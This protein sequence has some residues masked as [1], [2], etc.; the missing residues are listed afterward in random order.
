MIYGSDPAILDSD[1]FSEISLDQTVD[2][3]PNYS[4]AQQAYNPLQN[5]EPFIAE[6]DTREESTFNPIAQA[7]AIKDS[8]S[9]LPG[10]ASSVLSSFSSIL[11]G[12]AP[13]PQ[14]STPQ[15]EPISDSYNST[16]LPNQYQYSYYNYDQSNQQVEAPAGPPPTFYS[17]TDSSILQQP[18]AAPPT[19]AQPSNS[20]R[21][22]ERKKVS[23]AP[24]PGF[25]ANTGQPPISNSPAPP[26]APVTDP[27]TPKSN[28]S[29]FSLTTFF[30]SPLIDKIQNTVLP[31]SRLV[32]QP[33]A[34]Q[35]SDQFDISVQQTQ[36][37]PA[38]SNHP[39][40]THYF[41]P[42][43][44]NTQPFA[45]K[46]NVSQPLIANT[47]A[48]SPPAFP[49]PQIFT[50]SLSANTPATPTA[51]TP[52]Q[53]FPP[54]A[55]GQPTGQSFLQPTVSPLPSSLSTSAVSSASQ[56]PAP[57]QTPT[58]TA[59]NQLN[60]QQTAQTTGSGLPFGAP[61]SLPPSAAPQASASYRLKG[62]PLYRKPPADSSYNT[63]PAQIQ[64][65]SQPISD[66]RSSAEPVAAPQSPAVNIFN[67]FAATADTPV[68]P[69]TQIPPSIPPGP[70]PFYV[71]QATAGTQAQPP[72]QIQTSHPPGASP[73]YVPQ[74]NVETPVQSAF[75]IPTSEPAAPSPF[76]V[77]QIS[78]QPASQINIFN[79]SA[80]RSETLLQPDATIVTST[81]RSSPLPGDTVAT[82]L[83]ST[84]SP[85]A[86]QVPHLN[87]NPFASAPAPAST[88]L[89][90]PPPQSQEFSTVLPP[91]LCP[92][93]NPSQISIF[94]PAENQTDPIVLYQQSLQ[95]ILSAPAPPIAISSKQSDSTTALNDPRL[96]ASPFAPPPPN[97]SAVLAAIPLNP[98]SPSVS[99]A[100]PVLSPPRIQTS[101][102]N[103]SIFDPTTAEASRQAD[104]SPFYEFA[105]PE[106]QLPS[107][108]QAQFQINSFFA[109]PTTT[110]TPSPAISVGSSSVSQQKSSS[111]PPQPPPIIN[112]IFNSFESNVIQPQ[113][114]NPFRNQALNAIDDVLNHLT[115]DTDNN[116]ISAVDNSNKSDQASSVDES[117]VQAESRAIDPSSFFNNNFADVAPPTS[118]SNNTNEFQIQNFF[119][120]PPPLSDTQE[121]VQDK[122][123]NFIGTNLLNK[124]IEKIAS[125]ATKTGADTSETLSIASYIVEPPSSAQSE[126]SEYAEPPAI[127]IVNRSVEKIY[128]TVAANQVSSQCENRIQSRSK[129]N[130]SP[131]VL[132]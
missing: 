41:N 5:L 111:P 84:T 43:A 56:S 90:L 108:Q 59:P 35:T 17:P 58:P 11:K 68:Q 8:L 52:I 61:T 124:R 21:L 47:F 14:P 19:D 51:L 36:P 63:I 6:P 99:P 119:N 45:P 118:A 115:L 13:S 120:N 92:T 9:Q 40:P 32:E 31:A 44:F 81:P 54:Q 83:R 125:A 106:P 121:V 28:T 55:T 98:V 109:Q 71:S 94:N 93:P 96:T 117:S 78:S 128:S 110:E 65:L 89:N 113:D 42:Q 100:P 27:N 23:Y 112:N 10:V 18:S 76:N 85:F 34:Y 80:N 53:S 75:R 29:S 57:V 107:T 33:S 62:K 72:T 1:R 66:F 50:P 82:D 105:E 22:K 46:A 20:Y 104:K 24:I 48:T 26:P 74:A 122:N 97:S 102:F 70:S 103:A 67:P 37:V 77:P 132:W 49:A 2:S 4:A 87:S 131:V 39:V 91:S 15:N 126:F 12:T 38:P 60:F 16:A 79:P 64:P 30:S 3:E 129:S 86:A 123:F 95:I 88:P 130:S 101:P 25:S 116:N 114:F 7:T 127:D 73:F 69:T